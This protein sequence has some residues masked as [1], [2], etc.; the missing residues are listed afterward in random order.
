MVRRSL[1]V[2]L[3]IAMVAFAA[4]PAFAQGGASSSLISGTVVD[5]SGGAIPGASIEAKNAANGTVLTAVSGTNGSFNIPSVPSGTYSVTVTL[6]GFKTAVFNGVVVA[7]AQ[8]ATIAA[9]LEVGGVTE[10][11]ISEHNPQ[12]TFTEVR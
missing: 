4:A 2:V 7:A 8:P 6:Q 12:W 3:A 1:S 11:V 10:T 9:K 5:S